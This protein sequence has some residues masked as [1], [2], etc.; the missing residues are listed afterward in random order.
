MQLS[1][2]GA[3]GD[4]LSDTSFIQP[5]VSGKWIYSFSNETRVIARGAAGTTAVSDFDRLPSSLRFFTGGDKTIRG[6]GYNV[7]GP[8]IGD[9]VVGGKNLLESS[10]EYEVPVSE[11]WSFAAFVD[12]GDAFDSKPDYKTGLGLGVRWRSPIGPVRVDF[13]HAL[14]SPPGRNLRLHLTIG[15]DL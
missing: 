8:G 13:G 3:S 5:M 9:D 15:S 2:R 6:F 10:I 1:V 7:V 11:K 12:T 4:V 14:E